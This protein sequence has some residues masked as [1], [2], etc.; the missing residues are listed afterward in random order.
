MQDS[1]AVVNEVFNWAAILK[2]FVTLVAIPV[3]LYALRKGY[4]LAEKHLGIKLS[5]EQKADGEQAIVKGLRWSE[6]Q[7]RKKLLAGQPVPGEV[8]MQAA[9]IKA[10]EFSKNGLHTL[11]DLELED[12]IEA[13]LNVERPLLSSAPPPPTPS[14][15]PPALTLSKEAPIDLLNPSLGAPSKLPDF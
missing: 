13:K 4:L 1:P 11:S 10:R 9:I 15:L 12:L 14:I 5:A 3:A 6:E 2:E 8:K 7:A